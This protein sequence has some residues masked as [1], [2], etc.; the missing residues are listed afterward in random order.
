MILDE[1]RIPNAPE[2][3]AL[4]VD[5]SS[6]IVVSDRTARRDEEVTV[7]R[8]VSEL[9]S[10]SSSLPRPTTIAPPTP[11]APPPPPKSSKPP[12]PPLPRGALA[13]PSYNAEVWARGVSRAPAP[14]SFP[15]PPP[16]VGTASQRPSVRAP[17]AVPLS[18]RPIA[19][20]APVPA[21]TSPW[22]GAAAVL[23]VAAVAAGAFYMGRRNEPAAIVAPVAAPSPVAAVPSVTQVDPVSYACA[24]S[25]LTSTFQTLVDQTRGVAVA[26][27]GEDFRVLVAAAG[28]KVAEYTRAALGDAW[29]ET[30]SVDAV[31]KRADVVTVDVDGGSWKLERA[32]KTLVSSLVAATGTS[33][34][35]LDHA[36]A[37]SAPV[38]ARLGGRLYAAWSHQEEEDGPWAI[39]SVELKDGVLSQRA[40][41]QDSVSSMSPEI[42]PLEGGGAVLV[43]AEEK[44]EGARI[45]AQAVRADGT[46]SGARLLVSE[47]GK[48]AG[49]PRVT[50]LRGT[51]LGVA[52]LGAAG[53]G[54]TASFVRIACTVSHR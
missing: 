10:P 19:A 7:L 30:P 36:N 45:V 46:L 50:V 44:G 9:L 17:G 41:P 33:R 49:K 48:D 3:I 38:V 34:V 16:R 37:L 13:T 18:L 28:G 8:D 29:S 35:E 54:A 43:W 25:G 5:S 4:P 32:G 26:P 2:S 20:P 12:G 1:Q 14:S 42:A 24:T 27:V 53:A 23:A 47:P 51:T 31:E 40:W 39:R 21:P 52:Y 11:S 22:A 15:V 6:L